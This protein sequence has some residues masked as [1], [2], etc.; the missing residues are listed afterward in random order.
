MIQLNRIGLF[1]T[2]KKNQFENPPFLLVVAETGSAGLACGSQ[3]GRK[4]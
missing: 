2:A 3:V 4:D 1:I